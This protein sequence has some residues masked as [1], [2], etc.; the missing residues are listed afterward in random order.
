M[1]SSFQIPLFRH[2][3]MKNLDKQLLID[4]DRK[5]MVQTLA[6]VL[7]TYVQRPSLQRCGS[8]AKALTEKY[9]FLKDSF[10]EGEVC[11][12]LCMYIII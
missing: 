3:T 7:M 11:N 10:E 6:T 5:Y 4:S 1:P 9:P 12:I 8:V 2:G